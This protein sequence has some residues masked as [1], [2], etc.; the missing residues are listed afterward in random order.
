MPKTCT[1]SNGQQAVT[2]L[3]VES[4]QSDCS[5]LFPD[6]FLVSAAGFSSLNKT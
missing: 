2:P 1:F 4:G 5:E 3:A 6:N